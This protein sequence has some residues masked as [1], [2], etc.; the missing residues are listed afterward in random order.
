[1]KFLIL[2]IILLIL[3]PIFF[4]CSEEN[5]LL[6]HPEE[7]NKPSEPIQKIWLLEHINYTSDENLGMAVR[8]NITFSYTDNTWKLK[9]IDSGSNS[10]IIVD[11]RNNEVV[12]SM[13]RQT[14]LYTY[15]DSLLV[16]I[17]NERAE[18]V[19]HRTYRELISLGQPSRIKTQNDSSFFTYDGD[20]YLKRL[21]RYNKSGDT[22]P[23]YWE[24]YAVANGNINEIFTSSNFRHAYI[25]DNTEHSRAASFC[26]E[27]P[28]NT[29]SSIKGGC[30]LLSNL[31]FLYEYTGTKSKN[32]I[33]RTIITKEGE[34]SI[35]Y[36]DITYEYVLDKNDQV[37]SVKM[38]GFVNG[39]DI[40]DN[41]T[42]TFSYLEKEVKK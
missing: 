14:E 35:R 11:Y 12:Y 28:L 37:S 25:Y 6:Y 21:E 36:G 29:I 42:T 8:N 34:E 13:K 40:P 15:Y 5:V 30:W 22:T 39:M 41:Y 18:S 3:L 20:G 1:M 2:N 9:S 32:N 27:M 23:T 38:L 17:K 16:R 19:L 10:I 24:E 31:A 4:S 26:Y 33:I 7:E